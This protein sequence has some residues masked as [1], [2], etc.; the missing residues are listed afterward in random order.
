[1]NKLIVKDILDDYDMIP[2]AVANE[3]VDRIFREEKKTT[4]LSESITYLNSKLNKRYKASN[5]TTLKLLKS[6]EKDGVTYEEAIKVID[7]KYKQWADDRVMYKYLV[8]A[9]LFAN[10]NFH[11]YLDEAENDYQ[12]VKPIQTKAKGIL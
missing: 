12:V 1:M 10:I 4:S 3:I 6:L 9:T 7:Y 2:L 5:K 8:P 11:K